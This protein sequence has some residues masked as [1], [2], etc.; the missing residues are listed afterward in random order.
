MAERISRGVRMKRNKANERLSRIENGHFKR[1]E[2]NRKD[3]RMLEAVKA[4][5]LP[6]VPAIMSWISTKLN[7]RSSLLK[8]EDIQK[9]VATPLKPN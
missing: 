5:T 9:L 8:A 1:K 6:Y 4:G 7:K 3:E 2:R